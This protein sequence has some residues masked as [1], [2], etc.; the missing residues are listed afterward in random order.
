MNL[1][2]HS[3]NMLFNSFSTSFRLASCPT[4]LSMCCEES[5]KYMKKYFKNKNF[6][7]LG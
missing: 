5:L 1:S 3:K 6:Q 7:I 2:Q 4:Y